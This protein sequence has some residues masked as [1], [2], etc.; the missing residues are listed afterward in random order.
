MAQPNISARVRQR[1]R[2]RM[3][4]IGMVLLL[5]LGAAYYAYLFTQP[6]APAVP[7]RPPG[8]I[9]VPVAARDVPMG[10]AILRGNLRPMYVPPAGVP[11]DAIVQFS[12][13]YGRVAMRRIRAG[14]YLR[15]ADL[16]PPGAPAGLSGLA[17][18]GT[19]VVVV[20]AGRIGGYPGFLRPGD[21]V[22]V[23]SIS[24]GVTSVGPASP[25]EASSATVQGGGAQPGDPNARSRRGR[26][27][28]FNPNSIAAT[29]VAE[30]AEV[31]Q[32][33]NV[34]ARPNEQQLVLQMMPDDAHVT[35]L[36]LASGQSVRLVYRPFNERARTTPSTPI[37]K[38]THTPKDPRQIEMIHGVT[39]VREITSLD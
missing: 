29:L 11:A 19:R 13:V 30:D 6:K 17:R 33:P 23:L 38:Y 5:I 27:Q 15:E 8:T 2:R 10:D 26:N 20:E 18:P 39:R 9:E 12:Q 32:V 1:R 31:M 14:A 25:L 36:V 28:Q 7:V 24:T 21:R 35:M 22:D 37:D 4:I 16:A 3:I 34:R